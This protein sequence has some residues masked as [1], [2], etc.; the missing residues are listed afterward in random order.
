MPLLT[1]LLKTEMI[2]AKCVIN[3]TCKCTTR[4][5]ETRRKAANNLREDQKTDTISFCVRSK[6]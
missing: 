1:Q 6:I 5:T 4:A 3:K 2:D